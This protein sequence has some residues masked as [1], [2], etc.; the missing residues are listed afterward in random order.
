MDRICNFLKEDVFETT[1]RLQ[2]EGTV[3]DAVLLDPPA[4]VKSRSRLAEGLKGYRTVNRRAIHLVRP[5]GWLVSSSCSFHLDRD[6][7]IQL[8]SAAAY[9]AGRTLRLLDFRGAGADHPTLPAVPE[10]EYLKCAVCQVL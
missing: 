7:F 6:T 8:L 5:G 3:F 10:T 2:A 9:G 4:F 1:R